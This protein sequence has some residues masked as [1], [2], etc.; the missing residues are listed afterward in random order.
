MFVERAIN[1]LHEAAYG[2]LA[3]H[4]AILPGYPYATVVPYVPDE[5]HRPVVCIS[6]LAEHTKNLLADSRV[7]FSVLQAD[8]TDVQAA[9]RLTIVGEAER[10]EPSPAFLARYLRY[11]PGAEQ[12][13]AL[14]FMFFRLSARKVRF[15]EG[16]GRMGWL[17]KADL[18]AA[19][20]LPEED[21]ANVLREVSRAVLADVRV[22]GLDCYGI[23]Y[24]AG[25]LRKRFRFP[26]QP[27]L[28]ETI[29]DTVLNAIPGLS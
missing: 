13:L 5:A 28:P 4:S 17:E 26:S 12:L 24:A 7:S 19:Y 6:A 15:I 22:L 3:T 27:L 21:E 23:D 2:T 25:A 11:E 1:L 29:L 9:S 20:Q 16:L 18:D 8:A 10:F 14:D